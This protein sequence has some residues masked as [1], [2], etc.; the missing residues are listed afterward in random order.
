MAGVTTIVVILAA[1]PDLALD[2][3]EVFGGISLDAANLG[4]VAIDRGHAIAE[5]WIARELGMRPD[6]VCGRL[7]ASLEEGFRLGV[8]PGLLPIDLR[9][10]LRLLRLLLQVLMR[11]LKLSLPLYVFLRL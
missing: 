6:P 5:R 1:Q 4:D 10:R 11:L 2:G 7:G 8:A 9:R 3:M